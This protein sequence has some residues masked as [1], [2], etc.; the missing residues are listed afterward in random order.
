MR[1]F[2]FGMLIVT[3]ALT[4]CGD[5]KIKEL[6]SQFTKGCQSGGTS[7]AICS[8][9]F[10]KIEQKYSRNDLAAVADGRLPQ[11]FAAFALEASLQC[12]RDN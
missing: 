5:S 2:L 6:R 12:A 4:G 7:K 3:V 10:D 8:C 9:A 1:T 11:G